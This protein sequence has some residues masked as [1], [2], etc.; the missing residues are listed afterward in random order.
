MDILIQTVIAS[1]ATSGLIIWLFKS[2]I[3]ERLKQSI[4]S[5]YDQKIENFK[6]QLK[7]EFD[8]EVRKRK[9]YEDLSNSIED[10]FGDEDRESINYS[11][12]LNKLFGLLALYAPDD[13]YI[14]L[15][16]SLEG[17]VMPG[18]VKPIIYEALRKDLLKSSTKLT[19]TDLIKH[20]EANAL[21]EEVKAKHLE[22]K[23]V[24]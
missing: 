8:D 18:D 22:S 23:G 2:W 3:G 21:S 12:A 16:N 1:A 13:V 6:I 24:T 7:I 10:I 4:K 5:E 11:L 19:S 17:V 20:F 14:S 9:L 15:K